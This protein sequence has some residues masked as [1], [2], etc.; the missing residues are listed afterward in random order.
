MVKIDKIYT[1]AGDKGKTRL[2]TG[3]PLHKWHP[4]GGAACGWRHAGGAA[5]GAE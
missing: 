5:A 1:R 2:S 3:E 4:R